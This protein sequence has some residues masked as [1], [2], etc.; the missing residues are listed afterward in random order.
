MTVTEEPPME[1]TNTPEKTTTKEKNA[2]TSSSQQK[3]KKKNKKR[4]Q[5]KAKD[6]FEVVVIEE[7]PSLC[8]ISDHEND[9]SSTVSSL[10]D[11]RLGKSCPDSV[12]ENLES[13]QMVMVRSEILSY[14]CSLP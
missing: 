10:T 11:P 7:I 4:K 8:W 6:T 9:G 12:T 1:T 2:T 13:V 5:K 14:W 3:R